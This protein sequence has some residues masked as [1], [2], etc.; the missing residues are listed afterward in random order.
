M[1]SFNEFYI[2]VEDNL[3]NRD[4]VEHLREGVRGRV[5]NL[6]FWNK[7]RSFNVLANNYG[8]AS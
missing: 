6:F 8:S 3:L 4:K 5:K 2:S 1:G 7:V